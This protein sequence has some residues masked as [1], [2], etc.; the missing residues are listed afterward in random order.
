MTNDSTPTEDRLRDAI[1]VYTEQVE[2]A[3]DA[4]AKIRAGV[5][6]R[7][8]RRRFVLWSSVGVATAAAAIAAVV[9]LASL[10]TD[11]TQVVPRPAGPGEDVKFSEGFVGLTPEG[12]IRRFSADGEDLGLVADTEWFAGMNTDQ[13]N[14][15]V[16]PDG[17]TVYFSRSADA[18][19]CARADAL[20]TEIVA[21]P[22]AGGEPEVVVPVGTQPAIS[23]DGTKIAYVT[24][25]SAVQCNL[26]QPRAIEVRALDGSPVGDVLGPW[27]AEPS[28]YSILDLSWSPDSGSLLFTSGTGDPDAQGGGRIR[29]LDTTKAGTLADA[30][31]VIQGTMLNIPQRAAF[32]DETRIVGVLDLQPPARLVLLDA[33]TGEEIEEIAQLGDGYDYLTLH[34]R[35]GNILVMTGMPGPESTVLYAWNEEDGL[36][37]LELSTDLVDAL[38]LAGTGEV[39]PVDPELLPTETDEGNRADY[40][41]LGTESPKSAP[42]DRWTIGPIS[43]G[44]DVSDVIAVLG[45]VDESGENDQRMG[46]PFEHIWRLDN[47][48]V[49]TVD[50]ADE[51]QTE[52]L[53]IS[54]DVSSTDQG[55]WAL[56]DGVILGESTLGDWV[57]RWGR[58]DKVDVY[59]FRESPEFDDTAFFVPAYF[60]CREARYLMVGLFVDGPY[61]GSGEDPQTTDIDEIADQDLARRVERVSIGGVDTN[62]PC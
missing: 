41:S 14:L 48:N 43:I 52:I 37:R 21:V 35:D 51:S 19:D 61:V 17:K 44:D 32:F 57:D 45:E 18:G 1:S 25:T 22:I 46:S 13:P 39:A 49:V 5:D 50:T 23:P 60:V 27:P 59:G 55:R 33:A 31:V 58:P 6:A 20:G 12:E 38:L 62:E 29:M 42:S 47:G 10:G 56:A 11:T 16:S 54:V 36:H 4:W 7:Q 34:V 26:D 9:G 30:R 28:I 2:P 15:A 40:F 8:H 53:G 3:G 24:N